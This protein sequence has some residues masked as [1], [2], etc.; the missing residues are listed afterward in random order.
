MLRKKKAKEQSEKAKSESEKNQ[1][2]QDNTYTE[3]GGKPLTT[4]SKQSPSTS[5][6][7]RY[8]IY[9]NGKIKRENKAA[10]GYAQYIYV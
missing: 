9:H 3:N 2:T 4:A 5:D 7:T 10:T 8:H 1:S 6:T